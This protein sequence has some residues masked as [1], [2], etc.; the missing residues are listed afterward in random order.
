MDPLVVDR[1]AFSCVGKKFV[2]RKDLVFSFDKS[3]V[4]KALKCKIKK[5]LCVFQEVMCYSLIK[6]CSK[7]N[8]NRFMICF[9]D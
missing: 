2:L 4:S 7:M 6:H 1:F 9:R 3:L 5:D 8:R